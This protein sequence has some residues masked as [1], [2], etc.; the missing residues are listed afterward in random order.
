M[1]DRS[2]KE[3][4]EY[5]R[6][7][8]AQYP[9]VREYFDSILENGRQDGFV[10]TL[11]GRRRYIP[12]LN[13]SNKTIRAIAEREAINMPIQGTAADILKVAMIRLSQAIQ[14]R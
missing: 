6:K 9:R 14:E 10:S 2:P 8:F 5:I 3:S 13:E 7:F 1:I 12:A 4:T 11:Y